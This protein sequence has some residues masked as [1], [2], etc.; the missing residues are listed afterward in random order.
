MYAALH[1]SAASHPWSVIS[2]SSSENMKGVKT[3]LIGTS[4]DAG[5]SM[6]P[7]TA[8]ISRL[9]DGSGCVIQYSK[10]LLRMAATFHVSVESADGLFD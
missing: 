7:S 9:Y 6:K 1:G 10:G 5:D 2:E 4:F 3:S 8:T